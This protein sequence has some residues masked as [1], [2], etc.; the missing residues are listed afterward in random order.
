MDDVQDRRM[1]HLLDLQ[2]AA[3]PTLKDHISLHVLITSYQDG[4]LR[5]AQALRVAVQRGLRPPL[6]V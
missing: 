5:K 6:T 4:L 1:R 2:Q 3:G